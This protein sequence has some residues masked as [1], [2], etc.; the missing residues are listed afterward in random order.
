MTKFFDNL[1]CEKIPDE[2]NE[3]RPSQGYYRCTLKWNYSQIVDNI[4]EEHGQDNSAYVLGKA[5]RVLHGEIF[6][7]ITDKIH[8][9]KMHIQSMEDNLQRHEMLDILNVINNRVRILIT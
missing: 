5:R 7:D 2:F 1:S 8:E 9:L 6:G 3:Y 4:S